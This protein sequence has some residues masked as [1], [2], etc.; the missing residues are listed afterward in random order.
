MLHLSLSTLL[1]VPLQMLLD[2]YIVIIE[3]CI[4]LCIYL[5]QGTLELQYGLLG[6]THLKILFQHAAKADLYLQ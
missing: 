1:Y 2:I 5:D 3:V 4:I 6:S